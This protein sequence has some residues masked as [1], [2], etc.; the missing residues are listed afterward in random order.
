MSGPS[1]RIDI[2]GLYKTRFRMAD[3]DGKGYLDRTAARNGRFFTDVFDAMDRDG[4]GKVTEKEML[5]YY[6]QMESLRKL[7]ERS[8][9]SLRVANQ[10]RGLFDL[11][12][13]NGDGKLSVRELR[14]AVKLLALP[15]VGRNG[16]LARED[17]PRHFSAGLAPGPNGGRDP[18]GR[19]AAIA[20]S[21]EGRP[22]GPARRVGR[23]G[24]RRW[25]ATATATCRARSFSALTSSSGRS[26]RTATA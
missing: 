26:T 2:R 12:D 24:S 19:V 17:V 22:R 8:C 13:T 14:N 1:F 20:M 7:A 11:L 16:E 23:C 18:L 5:A 3:A 25:T 15:N 10:G 21:R 4:D 6:D 9:V